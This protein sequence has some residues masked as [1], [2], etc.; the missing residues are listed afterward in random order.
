MSRRTVGAIV[1]LAGL[2]A[3]GAAAPALAQPGSQNAAPGA[4]VVRS[5]DD[6]KLNGK[7]FRFAG[8]NNYYLMYRSQAEVDDVFADAAAAGFN[9]MRTWGFLDIGN[10][11][12]SGSIHHKEN[13]V[14]FQYWDG[15]KPAFNDGADGL[16][17]LDYV[18]A[19]ARRSGI[20]LVIPFTNNWSAFGGMDQYV[21]WRGGA[22]HDE[23]YT[24]AVIRGWFK[25]WIT[26]LLQRT[27]TITGVKYRDDPTIMAWEL[28][29]EPRCVGSGVYPRSAGCTDATITGWAADVSAHVKSIDSKHLVSAG[30]EGFLCTDPDSDDA[31]YNCR[32]GVNSLALAKL[33]TIDMMSMHLYPDH[34]STDVAWGEQ[35]IRRHG[36]LARTIGKPVMLGE[37]GLLDKATRNPV[38]QRWTNA[39]ISS[40]VDGFLYWILSGTQDD[41]TLYP[42]Y[43]GFTVYCPSPVCTTVTNAGDELRHGQRSRNPVADHDSAATLREEAV[44]L[45][46]TANDIA[47]RTKIQPRSLDLD[48][49]TAGRQGTATTAAGVFAA[50]ADG[51][52]TFTPA[53]GYTGKALA[54]YTVKDLAG[55]TSNAAELRVT[56]KAR[57]GDA[58]ILSAFEDGSDGWAPASWQANAGTVA[59]TADFHTGG[60]HGLHVTTADGGWFG[61]TGLAEP[62]DLSNKS[63]LRYDLRTGALGTSYSIAVQTGPD[64]TWCQSSWGWAEAGGTVTVEADLLDAMSCDSTALADVRAIYVWFNGGAEFDVDTLRA[65]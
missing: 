37:F 39:A 32:D 64:W 41:G 52:V 5:G 54:T 57:P 45:P 22:H 63:Y 40:G 25:D 29:N 44:V 56:V 33:P 31:A 16:E 47:Y 7:D 61:L 10:Q 36:Q 55:R 38:Y 28:A 11:D 65:E 26:H 2:L 53:A 6:L 21:R 9:V 27:N 20:K 23:F 13:G 18:L 46:A 58:L 12:D 42:D 35:W 8:S 60:A 34:W 15:T 30:D 1:A 14:Y 49:A 50:A 19:A 48:P 3:L 17:H 24:D 51:T 59:Q 62:L 43:D 4:F